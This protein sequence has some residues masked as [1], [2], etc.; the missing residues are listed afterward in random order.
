MLGQGFAATQKSMKK[1]SRRATHV[2]VVA[3]Q[4]GRELVLHGVVSAEQLREWLSNL[5]LS[6]L[7]ESC[8]IEGQS[9]S[10]YGPNNRVQVGCGNVLVIAGRT[11]G[12]GGY[13]KRKRICD[14]SAVVVYNLPA[15]PVV[16]SKSN[17]HVLS[18]DNVDVVAGGSSETHGQ[19]QPPC[20]LA[21]VIAGHVLPLTPVEPLEGPLSG[22]SMP[23]CHS[24]NPDS[25][26]LCHVLFNLNHRSAVRK[27]H[28]A[29]PHISKI[30]GLFARCK[31][32]LKWLG[33]HLLTGAASARQLIHVA[34]SMPPRLAGVQT[35]QGTGLLLPQRRQFAKSLSSLPDNIESKTH[36]HLHLR[37]VLY[38]RIDDDPSFP[39]ISSK[40]PEILDCGGLLPQLQARRTKQ[41]QQSHLDDCYDS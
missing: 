19:R 2:R 25:T 5:T 26:Y 37:T 21:E 30:S 17:M 10:F 39:P 20:R 4:L 29:H 28:D 23:A 13:G 11:E 35:W 9:T 24:C 22:P 14:S 12:G 41:K 36:L 6:S 27:P 15:V 3:R 16:S 8:K 34:T 7:L 38:F 18:T 40:S 32:L 33:A 31:R 1:Q